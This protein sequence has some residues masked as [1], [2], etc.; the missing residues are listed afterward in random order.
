MTFTTNAFDKVG[1]SGTVSYVN[2]QH[3]YVRFTTT[4]GISVGDTLFVKR[5]DSKLQPVLVVQNMSSISL[6]CKSLAEYVPKK[7]DSILAF[8]EFSILQKNEKEISSEIILEKS[9][10][11]VAVNDQI[12]EETKH[13]NPLAG[14]VNGRVSVNSYTNLS[15]NLNQYQRL[16]YNLSL[17]TGIKDTGSI[18]TTMYLSY[19]QKI[20][21]LSPFQHD[22]KVYSLTA[23]YNFDKL[24]SISLGRK[25]NPGMANIG[26]VDGVQFEKQNGNWSYGAVAG[27]RPDMTNYGFNPRLMQFGAFG[28]YKSEKL[29]MQSTVAFFNQLNNWNTDRRF[30]YVQHNQQIAPTLSFFGSAELDLYSIE[31]GVVK[32]NI[33]LTGLYLSV[34]YRPQQKLSLSLNYDARRNVFYYETY[35]NFADSLYDRE[36][37]Q[38]MRLQVLWRPS[39]HL[40]WNTYAGYRI[41]NQI[42]NASMNG[43]S[44]LTYTELPWIGGSITARI[45]GLSVNYLSGYILAGEFEHE[46][47]NNINFNIDYQ[48]VNY[49]LLSSS[50][51]LKQHLV[52]IGAYWRVNKK[53]MISINNETSFELNSTF[54]NRL[55][56]NLTRRF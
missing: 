5:V 27:S 16:K 55:F 11:A 38:G 36:T 35:K 21:S 42:D 45:T 41:A 3:S 56:M 22:L 52:E 46:L 25:L 54:N 31:Q 48:F 8:P 29:K 18:N 30:M 4:E 23:S 24:S 1:V 39:A 20:S 9:Q 44:S 14:D 10:E 53:W 34:R 12:F 26:A 32:S 51:L 40:I 7:G 28:T 6:V 37:R 33:N 50:T 2:L 47:A 13:K 49:N 17:S 19:N 43:S 15:N